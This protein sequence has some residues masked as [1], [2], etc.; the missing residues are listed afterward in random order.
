[1][2]V[3]EYIK[4]IY[5]GANNIYTHISLFSIFGIFSILF[6][7]LFAHYLNSTILG[8]GPKTNTELAICIVFVVLI[9]IYMWGY[10]YNYSN[11]LLNNETTDLPDISFKSFYT[12]IRMLPI[13]I[14]WITYFITLFIIGLSLFNIKINP[15]KYSLYMSAILGLMPFVGAIWG[16]YS[17]EYKNNYN[18]YNPLQIFVIINKTLFKLFKLL[19]NI[20]ILVCIIS[21]IPYYIVKVS[22]SIT[23]PTYQLFCRLISL[24]VMLY[25]INIAHYVYIQGIV[26]II[27]NKLLK[28]TN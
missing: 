12:F 3:L 4:N 13:I 19:F 11:K 9:L 15:I 17:K 16:L 25:F 6:S 18:L 1:M 27:K 2:E 20:I 24:T 5:T 21:L 7:K 8:Y 26:D 22:F 14:T 10:L 28:R 23:N